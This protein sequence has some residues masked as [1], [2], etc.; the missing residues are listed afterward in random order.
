[1]SRIVV[2]WLKLPEE[3]LLRIFSCLP[4]SDLLAA[5]CAC[6]LWFKVSR[7]GLLWKERLERRYPIAHAQRLDPSLDSFGEKA[8]FLCVYRLFEEDVPRVCVET[9]LFH[10]DEVWHV[11]FSHKGQLV[12]S[13]SKDGR[14]AIWKVNIQF[15]LE[16]YDSIDFTDEEVMDVAWRHVQYSEFNS[17]DSLLLLSASGL[18]GSS[19]SGRIAVY[20]V[21]GKALL[22]EFANHPYD[23]YG[24]W[25]NNRQV[26]HGYMKFIGQGISETTF[27]ASD[28]FS[29]DSNAVCQLRC[30]DGGYP[31][32][33]CNLTCKVDSSNADKEYHT[34][35]IVFYTVGCD[36]PHELACSA[37][38]SG[39]RYDTD[40][41][42]LWSTD[43]MHSKVV[44][45]NGQIIGMSASPDQRYLYVN[46]RPF[47]DD[48]PKARQ[49]AVPALSSDVS[50]RVY[51]VKSSTE[52]E[53]IQ[54]L[55][56]HCCF[57]N[58]ERCFFIFLDV[59]EVYVAR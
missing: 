18:I 56:G 48:Y 15:Q 54:T 39:S 55:S 38:P 26:L 32:Q 23:I 50:M 10:E 28:V 1:M 25:L 37:L 19:Q 30:T 59:S 58:A 31:R 21:Q 2:M 24:T 33:V 35:D 47:T 3:L 9:K 12:C 41:P 14:A 46:C 44:D 11:A 42:A 8:S 36:N 34:Q 7:D 29:D 22:N 13:S 52:W 6:H 53:H 20:D 27:T 57:T 4:D 51:C 43:K 17:D 5:G 45:F 16:L 40:K 49:G